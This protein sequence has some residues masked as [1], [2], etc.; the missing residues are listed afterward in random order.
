MLANGTIGA[1]IFQTGGKS[2]LES[3]AILIA[4]Q[5]GPSAVGQAGIRNQIDAQA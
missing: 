1:R 4:T 3:G 2:R 5:L